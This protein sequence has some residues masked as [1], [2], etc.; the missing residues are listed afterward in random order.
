MEKRIVCQ[1]CKH[2]F[3]TWQPSK[4]HG[5]NAYGFK[6]QTIPSVVVKRSSGIDCSFFE[7]KN[8]S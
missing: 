2:Y 5:C 4:P 6:S 7:L 1:K 8:N 3:V